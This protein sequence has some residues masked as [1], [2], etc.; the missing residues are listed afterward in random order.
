MCVFNRKGVTA[1]EVPEGTPSR[2]PSEAELKS[3]SPWRPTLRNQTPVQTE[4]LRRQLAD[5]SN[6]PVRTSSP[7]RTLSPKP[8]MPP[9]LNNP[10]LRSRGSFSSLRQPLGPPDSKVMLKYNN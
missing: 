4:V 5:L 6:D 10:G 3:Q 8:G 1:A 9:G 2:G 7:L